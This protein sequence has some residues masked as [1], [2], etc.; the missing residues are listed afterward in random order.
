[1]KNKQ[2]TYNI[3]NQKQVID[4]N[5]FI[6][7][8]IQPNDKKLVKI[9]FKNTIHLPHLCNIIVQILVIF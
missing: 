1:M 2:K 4:F 5:A 6:Q 7:K 3:N 9:I 8:Q